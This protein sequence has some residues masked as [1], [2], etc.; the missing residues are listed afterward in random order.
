MKVLT[1]A[2]DT[3]SVVM[4]DPNGVGITT[5]RFDLGPG[6]CCLGCLDELMPG[7]GLGPGEGEPPMG[8]AEF[9]YLNTHKNSLELIYLYKNWKL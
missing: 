6:E 2:Y 5:R 3:S 8:D 1:S 9:G 7:P 4:L